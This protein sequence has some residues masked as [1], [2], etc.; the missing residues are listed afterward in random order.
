[1]SH[2]DYRSAGSLCPIDYRAKESPARGFA[3]QSLYGGERQGWC[4]RDHGRGES[5]LSSASRTRQCCTHRP[6]FA[7]ACSVAPQFEAAVHD[8]RRYTQLAPSRQ[9]AFGK[10][11]D[12]AF[13]GPA[14]A[15]WSQYAGGGGALHS[16]VRATFW[17]GG[18]P[19]AVWGGGRLRPAGWREPAGLQPLRKG[20]GGGA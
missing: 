14:V 8:F 17:V 15:G 12:S 19:G 5:R 13:R 6:G 9:L 1:A 4:W 16:G 10:F 2:Y 7:W 3:R 20:V 18:E 11:H